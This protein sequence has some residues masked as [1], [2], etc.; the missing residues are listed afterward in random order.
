MTGVIAWYI[1][2]GHNLAN[3]P[4]RTL[5]HKVVDY[6]LTD[7]GIAQATALATRLARQDAPTAIYSSPL[8][9]AIQTAEIIASATG[10]EVTIVEELREL[11]VGELDGRSDAEAWAIHDQ[12][13]SDWDAGN[14]HSAFPGGEDYHQVTGR[15][16]VG[17]RNALRHPAGSRVLVVGH[18]AIIRAAIPA[19]CPGTS[20]PAT[21]LHNCDMAEL[22]L[23][24]VPSGITGILNQWPVTLGEEST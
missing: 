22:E 8:R 13:L 17:L 21:D 10:G 20:K 19:I 7:L 2:H 1:R 15:L 16:A 11:N 24:P 12:V 3:Q 14:H 6:P 18:C 23:H 9:R 4:P 5:S